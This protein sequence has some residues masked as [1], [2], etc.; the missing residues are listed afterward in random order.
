[1]GYYLDQSKSIYINKSNNTTVDY[2]FVEYTK[3]TD[4]T[5]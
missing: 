3:T 5:Q 4:T 1:M 2:L